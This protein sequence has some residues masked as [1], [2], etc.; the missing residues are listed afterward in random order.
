LRPVDGEVFDRLPREVPQRISMAYANCD[1]GVIRSP[2][3]VTVLSRSE[4][5]GFSLRIIPRR[6]IGAPPVAQAAPL[7]MRGS[8][9]DNS[10]QQQIYPPPSPPQQ[11]YVPPQV[12]YS[13][14]Y[15]YG[16]YA[17]LRAYEAQEF[18]VRRADPMWPLA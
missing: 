11:P 14:F 10:R 15:T 16:E 3:P 6:P 8:Y 18:A 2:Q 7:P 5:D 17:Q 1:N 9:G 4:S 12:A 13:G